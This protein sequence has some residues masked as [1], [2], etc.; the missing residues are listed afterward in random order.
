MLLRHLAEEHVVQDKRE[1]AIMHGIDT[2]AQSSDAPQLAGLQPSV[3]SD[4]TQGKGSDA[5]QRALAMGYQ[6]NAQRRQN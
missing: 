5:W 6:I 2:T 1:Q 3:G 4:P